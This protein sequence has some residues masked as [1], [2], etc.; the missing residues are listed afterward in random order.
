[1]LL[2]YLMIFCEPARFGESGTRSELMN[3]AGEGT[4]DP[5]DC[6]LLIVKAA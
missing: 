3:H 1:M 5:K 4:R 6:C 2:P